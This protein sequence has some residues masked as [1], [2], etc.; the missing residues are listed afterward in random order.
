MKRNAFTIV[1]LLVV[2]AV[3]SLAIGIFLP[4]ARTPIVFAGVVAKKHSDLVNDYNCY[5]G[6]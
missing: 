4:L 5:R 1:E 6:F 2:I 3:I